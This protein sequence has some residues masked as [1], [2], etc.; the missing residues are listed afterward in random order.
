MFGAHLGMTNLTKL[1]AA[2]TAAGITAPL[3]FKI[4]GDIQRF[5]S[6]GQPNDKAGWYCLNDM[7]QITIGHFG[8]WRSGLQQFWSSEDQ[9][10]L[11]PGMLSDLQRMQKEQAQKVTINATT[12]H[13]AA[14]SIAAIVWNAASSIAGE[15]SHPYLIKKGVKAHGS[16]HIEADKVWGLTERLSRSLSGSLLVVPIWNESGSLRNLQ[17]IDSEGQK[18]PLT[19][20]E[21]K[22]CFTLIG[23]VSSKLIFAEGFATGASVHECTGHPVVVTFGSANLKAVAG[24]MR[25]K[26]P[27]VPF[28]F[29]ADDDWRKQ[30]N[31]GKTSAIAAARTVKGY[32]ASP[33]FDEARPEGATD[34]NDLHS[35]AGADAVR[36]GINSAEYHGLH[37]EVT[38]PAPPK[39]IITGKVV[40]LTNGADIK[41]EPIQWLWK[42]WLPQGKLTILAGFPGD[43]KTN[44][45]INMA[46]TVTSGGRW[47]DGTVAQIGNVLIWSGEDSAEDTLVPR[48]CAAGADLSK[49]FFIAGTDVEGKRRGFNPM[50]DLAQL[51]EVALKVGD[52]HLLIVDPLVAVVKGDSHKNAE[53]RRDLQPLVD[54]G[55]RLNLAVLGITH[56]SKGTAGANPAQRVIGSIA[57]VALPR[58]VLVVGKTQA[59]E[60]D[61]PRIMVRA[62][63]NIAPQGGGF[64]FDIEEAEPLPG[65]TA[66]RIQWGEFRDGDAAELLKTASN[67]T[68]DGI[69]SPSAVQRAEEFLRQLLSTSSLPWPQIKDQATSASVS[70][71]SLKRAAK[72]LRVLKAKGLQGV[73]YWTLQSD[74]PQCAH[75][76]QAVQVST[77]AP[78]DPVEPVDPLGG[79]DSAS[80]HFDRE[81]AKSNCS[82]VVEAVEQLKHSH[83]SST[84]LEI[85]EIVVYQ[86]GHL[87]ELGQSATATGNVKVGDRNVP[88]EHELAQLV[89]LAQLEQDRTGEHLPR[90]E[91]TDDQSFE[92]F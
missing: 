45:A 61:S 3:S 32:V 64:A 9:A 86:D 33:T 77:R 13:A 87:P 22:G 57:F 23:P 44:I 4:D 63:T 5:S 39:S 26:Y 11:T 75:A 29:A 46:A 70:M 25:A 54:L 38:V 21:M 72:N 24:S 55:S 43:G 6:N 62:K 91:S 27:G 69:A 40:V 37:I 59:E 76:T 35:I 60:F 20:G 47:P 50:E 66:T 56:F 16:R 53:T 12:E 90:H 18:R 88:V 65:I 78:V 36:A 49:C 8:D 67:A 14:A 41:P 83:E 58:M 79:Y 31:P 71:A 89:Q 81:L 30:G 84:N 17:F 34:F 52:I 7:G 74:S 1:S 51:E 28:I 73:S 80:T 15:L 10:T 42:D 48:L 82:L 19:G 85:S 2:M 92:D 68:D